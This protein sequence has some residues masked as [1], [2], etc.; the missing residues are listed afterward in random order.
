MSHLVTHS[1]LDEWKEEHCDNCGHSKTD[2][3][4]AP[5]DVFYGNGS[6]M[7]T[8]EGCMSLYENDGS[9]SKR[10]LKGDNPYPRCGCM[11]FV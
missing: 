6:Y 11:K 8:A 2:H 3:Y 5:R 4:D 7:Y 9:M 10:M 1:Q